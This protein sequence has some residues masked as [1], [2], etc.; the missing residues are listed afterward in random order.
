MFT[1]LQLIGKRSRRDRYDQRSRGN[2]KGHA[3]V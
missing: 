3:V 2:S 1:S